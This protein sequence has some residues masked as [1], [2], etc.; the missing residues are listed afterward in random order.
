M[1]IG[2]LVMLAGCSNV[3]QVANRRG[4]LADRETDIPSLAWQQRSDWRNVRDCGAVGDGVVDDT[5][6][7]QQ[8]FDRVKDGATVYLPAGSYRITRTLTLKGP[9]LGVLIVG[10]GRDTTLRW[11]GEAGGKLWMVDGVAYG[12]Y[13]GLSFDGSNQ[14][15]VGLFHHNDTRFVTEVTHQ[16]L[17]FRNF[18][19]AGILHNPASKQAL[20]ET[21]FENCLFADCRRGVAFLQ[22]NDYDY[23]FDG[24]EF[25][26]CTTSIE[27]RHGNFYIRNCRFEASREVDIYAEPEHGSSVRRC[28]SVGSRAF[29]QFNNAVS[30]LTIQDCR[31]ADWTSADGAVQ[32]NGAPVTLFDCE[33]TGGPAGSAPIRPGR[34]TQ[35]LILSRNAAPDATALV[36]K[37][38]YGAA[39]RTYDIPAGQRQG[40]RL[41]PTRRFL[42][43]RVAMPS[44]IFDAKRDFGAR[45]DGVTDD[46]AALQKAIDAARS[47]GKGALAYLPTGKYVVK[48]TLELSGRDYTLGGSGFRSG[49]LWRGAPDGTIL[50]VRDPRHLTLE[51]LAVGNHDTGSMDNRY[52]IHQSG[53]AKPSHMT[54]RGVFVYG[55]YQ[56]QPFRKGLQFTGLGPR[57]VDVMHAVQGNLRFSDC[58]RATVLANVGYEGAVVIEGKEPVRDGLLGFQTRLVTHT[59][60]G[61]YLR[62]NQSVVMSDFY[63]E[64][65]DSGFLFEGEPGLPPGRATIQGAKIHYTAPDGAA[66][67]INDYR[68]QISL[69]HDQFYSQP[70]R[71]II[72]Q[73]G[74][75]PVELLLTSIC[76]YGVEPDIQG[77]PAMKVALVG[78]S[79]IGRTLEQA[80]LVRDHIPEGA[81]GRL[82]DALDDLRRLGEADLRLNHPQ[83]L[84]KDE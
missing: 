26:R 12:R 40:A 44:K 55:M 36:A 50:A 30:P 33:F 25:R 46:T 75:S 74:A 59:P 5:A 9:L 69:G 35:R 27:C 15:S 7:I 71:A 24:C 18:T 29:I 63:F 37:P 45:G 64:N 48:A 1:M 82:S 22:F 4:E 53:S 70:K 56:K 79:A 61:L 28:V 68:G 66:V 13:V 20:A 32:I 77:T 16:H 31:V 17:A 62:D 49:L 73:Q 8:A 58:G 23:T 72:R 41:T 21:T 83:S 34:D 57:D 78:N 42:V 80:N 84:L 76:F 19:D 52:D 39:C 67:T 60:Q 81:L 10:H 3:D 11:D 51:H 14:A 43:E 38:V 2:S 65:S 54:Y 47:H 6:A